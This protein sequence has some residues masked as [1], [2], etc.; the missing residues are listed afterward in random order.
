MLI[1]P[2]LGY[3]RRYR[4]RGRELKHSGDRRMREASVASS[5]YG[6]PHPDAEVA[7]LEQTDALLLY[8]YSFWCDDQ[9]G[10]GGSTC[11]ASNWQSI[12]GLLRYVRE[13]H[14][15]LGTTALVGLW[16]VVWFHRFLNY[17]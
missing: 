14:E 2:L 9:A 4:N 8:V 7:A 6:A 17:S 13:R 10:G 5:S 11:V 15:K 16:S 3:F 1:K 12:F